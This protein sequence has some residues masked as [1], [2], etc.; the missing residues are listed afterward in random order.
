MFPA[1]DPVWKQ[2]QGPDEKEVSKG[3][4]ELQ[5]W[6]HISLVQITLFLMLKITAKE[7]T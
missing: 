3:E 5:D 4:E 6:M 1:L 2:N 7:D